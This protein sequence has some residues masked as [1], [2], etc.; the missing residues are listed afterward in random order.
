MNN[1]NHKNWKA[2]NVKIVYLKNFIFNLIQKIEQ[3]RKIFENNNINS[4]DFN[5][6]DNIDDAYRGNFN[7]N[8][9]NT[10]KIPF[11]DD[12]V[13]ESVDSEDSESISSLSDYGKSDHHFNSDTNAQMIV[14]NTVTQNGNERMIYSSSEDEKMDLDENQ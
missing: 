3:E 7:L 8:I 4:N 13:S 1:P 6:A 10:K 2:Q 11:G 5:S 12:S 14:Q 9:K